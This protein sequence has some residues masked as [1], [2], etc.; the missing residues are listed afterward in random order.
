MF[1]GTGGGLR[2]L[3]QESM[4][5]PKLQDLKP[6]FGVVGLRVGAQMFL[7]LWAPYFNI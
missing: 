7:Q 6:E 1:A 2:A 3:P 5:S 4:M